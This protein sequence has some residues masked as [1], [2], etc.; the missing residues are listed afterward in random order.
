VLG[1]ITRSSK[2]IAVAGTHGKTTTSAM[3]AHILRDSGT[4][5]TAFL[6]GISSNYNTNLL[7]GSGDT[8]KEWVVVEA[9]E[10]DRSFLTLHPQI[11]VITS[12]DADHL[13][14]YGNRENMVS[15]YNN[16]AAQTREDGT[17]IFKD[18]LAIQKHEA[19]VW[20]YSISGNATF[21]ASAITVK[22]QQY[23]FDLRTESGTIEEMRMSWPGRHNVE[24]AVAAYAAAH[25]AG[26]P[27]MKIRDALASFTGVRRRFDYQVRSR[28]ITYI[29]DYA[30]HP[31]ELRAAISS[32]RELYPG[33]KILGIFQPH[34]Y[35][36]TRDFAGG[37]GESLSL[38]D[39]LL[40]MDIY[41]AR[42]LPIPG[43]T[44]EMILDLVRIGSKSICPRELIISK[45]LDSDANVILT[46]GAGDIDQLVKPLANA[47]ISKFSV[48]TA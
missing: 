25:A 35:T 1:L 28:K 32:V 6:G 24:N 29:D 39:E 46:L 44:S 43:V 41:P 2:T 45:V 23:H 8:S 5:C 30:H 33:S 10:Y 40:L 22:D 14:I 15:T 16:F 42:E 12:L 36:R 37:F 19:R 3:I 47:L 27:P 31:E 26:V 9:D 11:T 18:G 20:T 38:L 48:Q 17:L 7:L 34:L 13:D 4:D 21:S